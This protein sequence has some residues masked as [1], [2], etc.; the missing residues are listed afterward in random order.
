MAKNG[1]RH[2]DCL[3]SLAPEEATRYAYKYTCNRGARTALISGLNDLAHLSGITVAKRNQNE[4]MER[5]LL[6]IL[7]GLEQRNHLFLVDGYCT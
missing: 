6:P 4:C 2:K 3:T 5:L 1:G 7:P